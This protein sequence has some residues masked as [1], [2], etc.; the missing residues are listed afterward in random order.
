MFFTPTSPGE[1]NGTPFG[2]V[3][4]PA[5]FLASARRPES[6]TSNVVFGK[7][8]LPI[9][10]LGN[11]SEQNGERGERYSLRKICVTRSLNTA[12]REMISKV[13]KLRSGLFQL[14]RSPSPCPLPAGRGNWLWP[15]L[16]CRKSADSLAAPDL[17]RDAGR[18]SLSQRERAGV[19]E[20]APPFQ[21]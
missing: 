16:D 9:P 21:A 7:H 10:C 19:R 13:V 3:N 12:A 4:W 1:A 6:S 15:F 14:S 11:A 5:P 18:F 8:Q 20:S 2:K 17:P